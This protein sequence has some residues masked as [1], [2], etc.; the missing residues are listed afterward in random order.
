MASGRPVGAFGQTAAGSGLIDALAAGP[1][2]RV[3]VTPP[4]ALGNNRSPAIAFSANR[5]ASFTCSVDGGPPQACTSPFA[6]PQ[7]GDGSHSFSATAT[8]AIGHQGSDTETF[9][10]DATPPV[11]TITRG[12]QGP[13]RNA[14]PTFGFSADDPAAALRC[15]FDSAPFAPCSGA[16]TH[17]PATRLPE[18]LHTFSVQAVDAATNVSPPAERSFDVDTRKPK[19]SIRKRPPK[20]TRSRRARFTFRADEPGVG[21]QCKLD[22]GRFRACGKRKTVRVRRGRHKFTARAADAAGN[23]GKKAF[24]WRVVR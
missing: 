15:R 9:A 8:D 20:R 24:R 7:L 23:R 5:A 14:R 21:F 3:E 10:I 6:P 18:G 11:A 1:P 4:P 13:T 12:A 2:P 19:V 16:S 22:S 17:A